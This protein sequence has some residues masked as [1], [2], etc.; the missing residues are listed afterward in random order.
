VDIPHLIDEYNRTKRPTGEPVMTQ[1]RLAELAGV[2]EATV[3][4]HVRGHMGLAPTTE[5]AYARA[6]GL[7]IDGLAN[8]A[9]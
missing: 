9:A 8:D 7:D 6:L 1:K 4:R 3:S 2:A 5:Q